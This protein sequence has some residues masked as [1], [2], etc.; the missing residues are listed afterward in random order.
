LKRGGLGRHAQPF[1]AI[2][3]NLSSTGGVWIRKLDEA[4]RYETRPRIACHLAEPPPLF[5][6]STCVGDLLRRPRHKVPPHQNLLW[7]RWIA[8]QQESATFPAGE[9]HLGTVH[10]K[11]VQHSLLQRLPFKAAVPCPY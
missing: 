9:T 3:A 7:E 5:P 11:V 6:V 8:D 10:A 4:R 1:D 2:V